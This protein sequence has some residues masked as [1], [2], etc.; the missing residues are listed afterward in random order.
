MVIILDHDPF[1][2]ATGM[3]SETGIEVTVA[4]HQKYKDLLLA[5]AT[6][7]VHH[8]NIF[9]SCKEYLPPI[10]CCSAAKQK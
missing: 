7:L 3:K 10:Q 4:L 9:F 1:F 8:K 6:D 2:I 5:I